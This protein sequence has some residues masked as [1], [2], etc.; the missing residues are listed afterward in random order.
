V[1]Y[2]ADSCNAVQF[3]NEARRRA[4]TFGDTIL[5]GPHAHEEGADAG[6]IPGWDGE[7]REDL[8]VSSNAHIGEKGREADDMENQSRGFFADQVGCV[9]LT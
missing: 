8:V 7:R 4:E 1:K 3:V 2:L 6:I 5:V 9:H